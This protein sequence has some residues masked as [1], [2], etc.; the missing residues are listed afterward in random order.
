MRNKKGQVIEQFGGLAVGV[1]A[2]AILLVVA[3]LIMDQGKDQAVDLIDA[4]NFNN[5]TISITPEVFYTFSKCVTTEA[6]SLTNVYNDTVSNGEVN[7]TGNWTISGRTVNF[8]NK[9]NEALN[10]STSINVTYSCKQPDEAYNS[11]ETLQNAT[12]DVPTWVPVIIVTFVGVI[13]LSLVALLRKRS[14][15]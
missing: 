8:S 1:A 10:F 5:E 13:L 2:L 15:V 9:D 6:V 3:F 11:T 12:N 14:N 4:D 7:G